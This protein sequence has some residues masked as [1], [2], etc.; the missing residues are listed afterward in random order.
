MQFQVPQFIETEDKVIGPFTIRQFI[1]IGIAGAFSFFLY[2]TVQTWL[3]SIASVFLFAA[4]GAFAFVKI[5]G[6]PL[7]H[8]AQSALGFYWKPQIYVWQPEHPEI[9]KSEALRPLAASNLSLENILSGQALRNVWQNLQ[10]GSKISPKQ[11]GSRIQER[12]QVFQ[13]LTGER[14][15]A[16]RVDYR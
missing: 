7:V 11:I 9:Q 12:Y 4:A 14:Q 6:R 16:R 3:F 15:A 1:Y 2:F 10:T 8:I 5:S 13:R